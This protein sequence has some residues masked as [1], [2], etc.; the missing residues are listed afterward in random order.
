VQATS[1]VPNCFVGKPDTKKFA[2]AD[3]AA[4]ESVLAHR[5]SSRLPKEVTDAA[6]TQRR[7][8]SGLIAERHA[9]F[10]G[11]VYDGPIGSKGEVLAVQIN[12]A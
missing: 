10:V 5:A 12:K 8:M 11:A 2:I 6:E 1:R 3:P 4:S 7:G 9:V